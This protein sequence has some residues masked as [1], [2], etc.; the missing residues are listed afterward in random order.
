MVHIYTWVAILLEHSIY[1]NVVP[2]KKQPSSEKIIYRARFYFVFLN[3]GADET[4]S[5]YLEFR[6][7]DGSNAAIKGI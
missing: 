3:Q 1:R 5:E 4:E 7:N 6:L 2:C